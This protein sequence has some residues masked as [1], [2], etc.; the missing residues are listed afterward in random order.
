MKRQ[1]ST[2]N[3]NQPSTVSIIT[4]N[5]TKIRLTHNQNQNQSQNL[6][7]TSTTRP[8]LNSL[9]RQPTQKD[10]RLLS[11]GRLYGQISKKQLLFKGG[12]KRMG[13]VKELSA[14]TVGSYNAG[15]SGNGRVGTAFTARSCLSGSHNNLPGQQHPGSASGYRQEEVDKL[16]AEFNSRLKSL[17]LFQATKY[18]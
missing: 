13:S 11:Q 2:Y 3:H 9:Y 17:S 18:Q 7:K 14:G 16:M 4:T 12:I 8:R 5:Q 1:S 10:E 15:S 6:K